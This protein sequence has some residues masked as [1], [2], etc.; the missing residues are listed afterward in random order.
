GCKP[1]L[2]ASSSTGA[3]RRK[4]DVATGRP[5]KLTP[6]ATSFGPSDA[7]LSLSSLFPLI[8]R[9][10]QLDKAVSSRILKD[11]LILRDGLYDLFVLRVESRSQDRV[12]AICHPIN[13]F[14]HRVET[15]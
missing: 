15:W 13:R 5:S 14:G 8:R 6:V 11:S 1:R 7:A 4:S 10:Q 2:S 12:V 9:L 3:L